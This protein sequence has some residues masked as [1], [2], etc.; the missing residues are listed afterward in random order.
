MLLKH[1]IGITWFLGWVVAV[2]QAI[3]NLI[4][5][6]RNR[7]PERLA[8]QTKAGIQ[9]IRLVAHDQGAGPYSEEDLRAILRKAGL[10]ETRVLPIIWE[11]EESGHAEKNATLSGAVSWVVT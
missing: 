6:R 4:D 1:W 8:M 7:L 2:W 3:D 9:A 5:K 10:D 11:L